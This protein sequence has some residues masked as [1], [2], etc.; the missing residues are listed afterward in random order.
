MFVSVLTIGFLTLATDVWRAEA[1]LVPQGSILTA[2]TW[3]ALLGL[4]L[5]TTFL[6]WAWFAFVRPP[7]FSRG[8]AQ[9]F[10]SA[11]YRTVINGSQTEL[12][13]VA[14]EFQR[15]VSS[16]IRHAPQRD[17]HR[18][19][20]ADARPT[21]SNTA[22][23][24]NEV[25]LLLGDRRLC[26]AMVI[27]A[28]GT[29]WGIFEEIGRSEK[30]QIPIETFARNIFAEALAN[31][32]SFLYHETEGY[33]TGLIGFQKPV[34]QAMF[35]N[36]LIV[37]ENP[38]VFDPDF[39]ETRRWDA[40]QWEAY[41]RMALVT[42]RDYSRRGF[43]GNSRPI[44]S[45]INHIKQACSDLYKLD[46][47]ASIDWNSDLIERLR[48]V[49]D[50]ITEAMKILAD[51][52]LPPNTSLRAR[53]KYGWNHTICDDLAE[54]IAEVIYEAAGVRSPVM[55]CWIVQHNMVWGELFNFSK[56]QS[57]ATRVVQFKVR[58]LLYDEIKE[59]S[60]FPNY[61]GARILSF[62]LNVLGI[63]PK[64]K[65]Y[66]RDSLPL[67]KAVLSWTVR[68]FDRLY[69]SHPTIA[70]ECLVE[71]QSYERRRRRIVK[72]HPA[73]LSETPQYEYLEVRS[74]LPANS[75]NQ[76]S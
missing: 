41:F 63:T 14:E 17:R 53:Q 56:G 75:G 31:K 69:N 30:Y 23:C 11:M 67:Q 35:G 9:R 72:T 2:A 6:V 28:P 22:Q 60:D 43:I 36:S 68:N 42:L 54:A 55:R 48:T 5:L 64:E 29:I 10:L 3:Q 16:V 19:L 12:A 65:E 74:G 34:S 76:E 70:K 7:V 45:P 47:A 37:E 52:G 39:R 1:W 71:G 44:H 20:R 61:K 15:S 49:M 8:N 73:G 27:A 21:L 51:D 46:R 4:L 33:Y 59:M 25:L 24:A 32:D 13:I 50:F 62:C 38:G 40:S 57:H 66:F 58:R 18:A 26:R